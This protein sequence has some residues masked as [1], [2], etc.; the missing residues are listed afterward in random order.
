[1]RRAAVALLA[2][3]ALALAV[4]VAV[5]ATEKRDF[6]FS[7]GVRPVM[8]ATELRPTDGVC[9]IPIEA[10][11]PFSRVRFQVGTYHR[12]G[13]RLAIL[14]R[15]APSGRILARGALPPGYRDLSVQEVKLSRR[16][17]GHGRISVCFRNAGSGK[18]A[19]YGNKI[20]RQM[21]GGRVDAQ[22]IAGRDF[23]IEFTDPPPKTLL[24]LF[25]DMFERASL[26]KAGW[27]GAW[28]FW[29]LGLAVVGVVP[30]VLGLALRSLRRE[31][32]G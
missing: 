23:T 27:V 29:L 3:V 5:A 21:V 31:P 20:E 9:Q 15:S 16:V 1:M 18:A 8:L 32:G 25:P 30:L 4:L 12:S 11:A 17:A 22:P 28:T 10:V 24:S 13:S 26:F 2:V 7:P 19:I 6:A 14:V